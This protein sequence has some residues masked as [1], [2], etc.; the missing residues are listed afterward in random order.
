MTSYPAC[1]KTRYLGNHAS[2]IKVTI[3]RYQEV[4]IALSESVIKN[5]LKRPLAKKSRWRHIRLPIKPR[6]LGNHASQ[7]QS[8]YGTPSGNHSRSFR[9]RQE[10]PHGAPP[11]GEIMMTSYP[12]CNKTSLPRKPC[13]PDKSYNGTLS[14]SHG[15]SFRIRQKHR[16]KRP[17]RRT[18]D[19]MS[20]WQ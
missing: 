17:W 8:C 12:A 3:E 18:D 20:G 1:N 15:R 16:L 6:Y 10:N 5:P 4:I 13:I 2:Q 9:V 19:V 11:G 14:G 7:I